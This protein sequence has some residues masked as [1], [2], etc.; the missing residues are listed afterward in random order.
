V[1]AAGSLIIGIDWQYAMTLESLYLKA[2]KPAEPEDTEAAERMAQQ[3][4]TDARRDRSL[5]RSKSRKGAKGGVLTKQPTAAGEANDVVP[6]VKPG[7][8]KLAPLQNGRE[9]Q[10]TEL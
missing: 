3:E 5:K 7:I 9:V 4:A 1:L 10:L 6:F 8:V 2:N